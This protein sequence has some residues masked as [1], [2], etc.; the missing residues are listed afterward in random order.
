MKNEDMKTLESLP[1]NFSVKVTNKIDFDMLMLFFYN[2][3]IE[4]A[5]GRSAIEKIY[6]TSCNGY[7]N[8][9][10]ADEKIIYKSE[11]PS[12]NNVIPISDIIKFK[13]NKIKKSRNRSI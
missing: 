9:I 12:S 5:S 6:D 1:R 13:Y 4:W 2:N 3:E 8:Y 11:Y 7:I 10:P